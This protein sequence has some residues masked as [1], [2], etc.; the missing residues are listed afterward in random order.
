MKPELPAQASLE[1]SPV[2]EMTL[3]H[4]DITGLL[5]QTLDKAIRLGELLT[6]QKAALEHGQFGQWVGEN[7]PFSLRTA[8]RYMGIHRNRD[9]LKSDT[10]S[11]LG[12]AYKLLQGP[13]EPVKQKSLLEQQQDL[14][15]RGLDIWCDMGG[16][17]TEMNDLLRPEA[18]HTIV[19]T[20]YENIVFH[21]ERKA[22]GV[23]TRKPEGGWAEQ[24]YTS[25]DMWWFLDKHVGIAK[26][27]AIWDDPEIVLSKEDTQR[28]K[29]A[30]RTKGFREVWND[31]SFWHDLA[32]ASRDMANRDVRSSIESAQKLYEGLMSAYDRLCDLY[33][34]S[35]GIDVPELAG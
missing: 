24:R 14:A 2:E 35:M 13:S 31:D 33:G 9:S 30:I 10:V 6:D 29:S 18:G 25:D 12:Q 11:H 4:R 17:M 7:L 32:Q 23:F 21:I 16:A 27:R 8:Q 1:K 22:L 3:L 20:T 15:E 34:Q 5:N 28:I 19:G 26:V